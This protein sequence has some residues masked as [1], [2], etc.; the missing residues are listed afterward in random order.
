MAAKGRMVDMKRKNYEATVGSSENDMKP[1]PTDVKNKMDYIKK[2]DMSAETRALPDEVVKPP[3]GIGSSENDM[4]PNPKK[5]VVEGAKAGVGG[6]ALGMK[7]GGKVSQLAKANGCA[8]RGKTKG[9]I[10]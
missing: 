5:G 6:K 3:K 10:C 1:L 2:G 9:K 4:L 7:K 8:V